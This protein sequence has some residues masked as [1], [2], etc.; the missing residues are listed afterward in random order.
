M[1][2]KMKTFAASHETAVTVALG[3]VAGSVLAVALV[4]LDTIQNP[5]DYPT[6]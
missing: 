6:N 2:N 5:E 4:K 1:L 3:I